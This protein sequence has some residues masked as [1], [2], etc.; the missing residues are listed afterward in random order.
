M[1]ILWCTGTRAPRASPPAHRRTVRKSSAITLRV[2]SRGMASLSALTKPSSLNGSKRSFRTPTSRSV[3]T[4]CST[5]PRDYR[6]AS[7]RQSGWCNF[8]ASSPSSSS[9]VAFSASNA[10][11]SLALFASLRATSTTSS[12]WPTSSSSTCSQLGTSTKGRGAYTASAS[13]SPP[14]RRRP[15]EKLLTSTSRSTSTRISTTTL[16]STTRSF[17][18]PSTRSST[19]RTPTSRVSSLARLSMEL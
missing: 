4:S 1:S 3:P 7:R 17:T 14:N 16:R 10:S 12:P 15:T 9:T 19:F 6:W 13:C 18:R 8:S 2:N 11:T 5:S